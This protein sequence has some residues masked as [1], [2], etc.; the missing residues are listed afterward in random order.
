MLDTGWFR[1]SCTR[2]EKFVESLGMAF[3]IYKAEKLWRARL[4]DARSA[5]LNRPASFREVL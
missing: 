4:N 3:T 5:L 1:A 2:N